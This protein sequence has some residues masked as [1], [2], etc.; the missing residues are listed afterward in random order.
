MASLPS[1][2]FVAKDAP[3]KGVLVVLAGKDAGLA[4]SAGDAVRSLVT[5]AAGVARFKGK[6]SR[7]P[8]SMPTG[9]W[10]SARMPTSR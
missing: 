10:S 8:M 1:I 5:R 7:P 6:S 3:A 2:E 9:C 4:A